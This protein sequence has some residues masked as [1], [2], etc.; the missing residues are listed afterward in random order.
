MEIS[1]PIPPQVPTSAVP[2]WYNNCTSTPTSGQIQCILPLIGPVGFITNQTPVL[3][4]Y[5]NIN[6]SSYCNNAIYKQEE[7][8]ICSSLKCGNNQVTA[9]CTCNENYINCNRIGCSGTCQCVSLCYDIDKTGSCPLGKYNNYYTNRPNIDT[10]CNYSTT[11]SNLP[12]NGSNLPSQFVTPMVLR[13]SL[14]KYLTAWMQTLYGDPNGSNQFHQQ[15][16]LF[17]PANGDFFRNAVLNTSGALQYARYFPKDFINVMLATASY[18]Q[19]IYKVPNTFM[20]VLYLYNTDQANPIIS[21]LDTSTIIQNLTTE[22]GSKKPILSAPSNSFDTAYP[23]SSNDLYN[24][25]YYIIVDL[26]NLKVYNNNISDFSQ[27]VSV[28]DLKKRSPNGDF[29]IVGRIYLTTIITWSANL[30]YLFAKSVNNNLPYDTFG[31]NGFC[32][33]IKLDTNLPP[34]QCYQNTCSTSFNEICKSLIQT[35]C[36]EFNVYNTKY[37]GIVPDAQK[38]FLN[39]NSYSCDCYNS[40]LAP[41][42]TMPPVYAGMCFDNHCSANQQLLNAFGLTDTTCQDYCKTIYGWLTNTENPSRQPEVLDA[43]KYQRLCGNYQPS[44]SNSKFNN[45][46]LG[47]G[48]I[49]TIIICF[50]ILL[51]PIINHKKVGISRIIVVIITIII[52]LVIT[53]F[54]AKDFNGVPTCQDGQQICNTSITH[55]PIPN[56]W[57]SYRKGCECINYGYPCPDNKGICLSGKCFPLPNPEPSPA[58]NHN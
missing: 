28:T 45:Y 31:T 3:Q 48:V 38:F 58:P 20:V 39:N 18:P 27:L 49:I 12:W 37:S 57:C 17:P 10:I 24:N 47:I 50:L 5:P 16:Y 1:L 7:E 21:S 43:A 54:L 8:H 40:R 13:Y 14:T 55:I 25:K 34:T 53:F 42:L 9:N 30:F 2:T 19:F 46:A 36:P 23:P 6:S 52:L 29:Y 15:N 44:T 32:D 26:T 56:N 4:Q 33:K 41:P 11:D 51:D 35:F 22:T